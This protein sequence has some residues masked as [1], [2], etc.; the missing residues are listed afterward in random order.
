MLWTTRSSRRASLM[1]EHVNTSAYMSCHSV[2]CE[3]TPLQ[4][5]IRFWPSAAISRI[6]CCRVEAAQASGCGHADI[7]ECCRSSARSAHSIPSSPASSSSSCKLL[8]QQLASCLNGRRRSRCVAR[9]DGTPGGA[10]RDE[11]PPQRR[12]S[13][14]AVS[15]ARLRHGTAAAAAAASQASVS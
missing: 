13:A 12:R 15:R 5:M 11:D 9:G 8:Q 2:N 4:S 1:K 6:H 14:F 3:L 10:A 7:R